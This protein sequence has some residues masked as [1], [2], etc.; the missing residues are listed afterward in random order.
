MRTIR[1]KAINIRLTSNELKLIQYHANS[2]NITTTELVRREVLH[3]LTNN[4][5]EKE[6]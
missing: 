1:D 5:N 2:L 4:E 3:G 6:Q